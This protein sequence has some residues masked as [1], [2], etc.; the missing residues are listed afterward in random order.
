MKL[1][2]CHIQNFGKL[3]DL[4]YEFDPGV[5]VINEENGFG[6]STL[7]AFIKVMFFGF[8]NEKSRDGLVNERK[9]YMPWQTGPYGGSIR[10]SAR[11][12]EYSVARIFGDRP[13]DD[14]FSIY[15]AV[16][17]LES[18]DFTENIGEELFGI[19]SGSFKRTVF[20]SQ[21]DVTTEAT[22]SINAKMG[23]LSVMT[24][25]L[26][27]FE[28]VDKN[29]KDRIN[30]LSP[31]RA[32]GEISK[33]RTKI[34]E[35]QNELRNKPGVEKNILAIKEKDNSLR[36]E[37]GIV[38]E[39]RNELTE[40][41]REISRKQEL[42]RKKA[43]YLGM[44]EKAD[45]AKEKVFSVTLGSGEE[46][47]L[48]RVQDIF[49]GNIPS[50]D[51]ID[52]LASDVDRL[53]ELADSERRNRIP[54]SDFARF[55]EL[56]EIF[57]DTGI[58]ENAASHA[59]ADYNEKNVIM[60]GIND[61]KNLLAAYKREEESRKK[62]K[63]NRLFISLVMVGILLMIAG[64]VLIV[65]K[66]LIGSVAILIL[67][68]AAIFF[69]LVIK[70]KK[71]YIGNDAEKE[72]ED[73][74][75]E[76][77]EVISEE[78]KRASRLDDNIEKMLSLTDIEA[79]KNPSERLSAI[80]NLAY[81]YEL[82]GQDI[83]EKK[84]GSRMDEIS[85]LNDSIRE[86]IGRYYFLSDEDLPE[87][88]FTYD[89]YI[90]ELEEYVRKLRKDVNLCVNLSAKKA[91]Y[92]RSIKTYEERKNAADLFLRNTPYLSDY[93]S[94]DAQDDEV[95]SEEMDAL[96]EELGSTNQKVEEMMSKLHSYDKQLNELFETLETLRDY[97]T[98]LTALTEENDK[99]SERYRL[100]KLTR[101]YLGE[102]R[103]RFTA[104]YM[105]PLLK[106][107]GKYYEKLRGEKSDNY[108]IDANMKLS[109]NEYGT[110]RDTGYLSRGSQDLVGIAFRM[111][112]I[113]AMYRDEKPFAVFDDP[114]TDFDE[115]KV[116]NGLMFLK[117]ISE[118][119]QIIYFTCHS[120]RII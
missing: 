7:A 12:K 97:E 88:Y 32:T 79:G 17:N 53:R 101:D 71:I 5:N 115:E 60:A 40:K 69:G 21:S 106:S 116:H 46:E 19:D 35:I 74:I 31:K 90:K 73:R 95:S 52:K 2:S 4:T 83:E 114:F 36:K 11:G 28:K 99:L 64:L 100:L 89:S 112:L 50:D 72:G 96:S 119:Y 81:E 3:H 44:L 76:L 104:Q 105:A 37:L 25:D 14:S 58:T 48:R 30:S 102:A 18:T 78:E 8:D 43:E 15:D 82:L 22:D 45:A 84:A 24:D 86:R 59:I 27:R 108:S 55:N 47:D 68:L 67:G 1:I 107:F 29:L 54:D 20:I 98:E 33:L 61:K 70:V 80:R 57:K 113:E 65:N 9:R 93:I 13:K 91:E 41:S 62:S 103:V 6:K 66:M 87:S 94:S 75:L 26:A 120:S 56:S 111:A 77:S 92:L 34:A 16:T 42:G 109:V 118:D 10:F 51:E 110:A 49:S 23:N 117:E 38:K 63:V 85:G 39:K